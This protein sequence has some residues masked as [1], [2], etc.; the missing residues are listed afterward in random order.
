MSSS[1]PNINLAVADFLLAPFEAK[2]K[3]YFMRILRSKDYVSAPTLDIKFTDGNQVWKAQV[4][5]ALKPS[6]FIDVKEDEYIRQIIS[7]L[8][9]QDVL[10]EKFSYVLTHV[11]DSDDLELQVNFVAGRARLQ[12]AVL[13]LQACNGSVSIIDTLRELRTRLQDTE[14]KLL[15]EVSSKEKYKKQVK[16]ISLICVLVLISFCSVKSKRSCSKKL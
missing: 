10:E 13:R 9:N 6:S 16:V 12:Y 2:G 4:S 14:S 1:K 7:A 11:E 3:D 5:A 15:T 8:T